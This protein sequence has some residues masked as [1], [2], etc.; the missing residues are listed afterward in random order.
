MSTLKAKKAKCDRAKVVQRAHHG[1]TTKFIKEVNELVGGDP[2]TI[3]ASTSLKVIYE[4]QTVNCV[5]KVK[6]MRIFLCYVSWTKSNAKW[7]KSYNCQNHKVYKRHIDDNLQGGSSG[8]SCLQ[9]R[10]LVKLFLAVL[11]RVY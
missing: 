8:S 10:L 2:T 4:Q 9:V 6:L 7:K 11:E 1:V 5:S 3:K